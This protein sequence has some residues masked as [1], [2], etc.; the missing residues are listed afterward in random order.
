[1]DQRATLYKRLV[2]DTRCVVT[3]VTSQDPVELQ[4]ADHRH[5]R[6]TPKGQQDSSGQRE[7]NGEAGYHQG[8]EK[9]AP[10]RVG[11]TLKS[12]GDL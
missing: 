5:P 1:L 12:N 4:L 8:Q 9:P 7:D 11:V 6:A 3:I 10:D 2:Q